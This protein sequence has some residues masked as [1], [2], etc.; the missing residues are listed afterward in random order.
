MSVGPSGVAS[1]ASKVFAYLYLKK[2]LN[3]VSNTAPFIAAAASRPGATNWSYG[4]IWPP[5]PL[6]VAD[7]RADADADRA[8]GTAAAR[9]S[10]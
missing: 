8:R 9:R 5:G 7:E 10:R 2:K 4:T 6:T 1:I 3:V